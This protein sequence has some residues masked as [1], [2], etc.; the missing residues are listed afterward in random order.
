MTPRIK[1]FMNFKLVI[2]AKVGI[3][4]CSST[5]MPAEDCPCEGRAGITEKQPVRVIKQK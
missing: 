2:P 3:Q 1:T 4:E 5:S